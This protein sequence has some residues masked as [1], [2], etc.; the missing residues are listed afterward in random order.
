MRLPLLSHTDRASP[1]AFRDEQPIQ[2]DTFLA[3]VAALAA[4]LPARTHL[5]NLCSDRYRFTVIADLFNAL[6][7]NAVTNFNLLNGTQFN[8][9]IAP[10]D[11]RT[12][13]LG[14]RFEF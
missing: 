14:L 6:N 7:S 2:V 4:R 5:V 1:V 12:A 8:R 9:I 3:D 13:M 11:P 10:L